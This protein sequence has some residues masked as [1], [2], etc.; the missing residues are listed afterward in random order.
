MGLAAV[1]KNVRIVRRELCRSVQSV[2][3]VLGVFLC[4]FDN[5]E[6]HPS[7]GI[8]GI[9]RSLFTQDGDSLV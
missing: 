3:R 2:C 5:P 1:I 4:E 9:R 6:P 8:L 7:D